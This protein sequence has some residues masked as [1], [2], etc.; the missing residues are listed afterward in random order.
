MSGWG[1]GC[2]PDA[3][4]CSCC[5]DPPT[6]PAC[7]SWAHACCVA[8]GG[9]YGDGWGVTYLVWASARG[10]GGGGR[11]MWCRPMWVH[12]LLDAPACVLHMSGLCDH[13]LRG[14]WWLWRRCHHVRASCV[15]AVTR[16]SGWA[17]LLKLSRPAGGRTQHSTVSRDEMHSVWQTLAIWGPG[18][19]SAARYL[20]QHGWAPTKLWYCSNNSFRQYLHF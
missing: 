15:H 5:C 11:Y 4:C 20:S 2:T 10:K 17:L 14:A 16:G 1:G 8:L 18:S 13:R 7:V 3:R 12:M 6:P 19:E 9:V